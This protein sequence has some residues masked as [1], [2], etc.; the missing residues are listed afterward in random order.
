LLNAVTNTALKKPAVTFTDKEIEIIH[1]ICQ[2]YTTKE[3][4]EKLF[5]STRTVDGYRTRLLEKMDVK[6]SVGIVIYAIQNGIYQP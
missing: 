5:M 1:L 3:I 4:G 2:E 6:N